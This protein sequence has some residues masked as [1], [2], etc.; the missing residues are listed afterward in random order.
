VVLVSGSGPQDRD[1][2]LFGHKPFL[3]LADHLA[4]SGIGVLRYD[5]RGVGESEGDFASATTEDFATDA[6][7]AVDYLVEHPGADPARVGIIGHSE[8][9]IVAPIAATRSRRVAFVVSLA[10]T[11]IPGR[12]LLEL[13]TR[14][15]L[16]ASGVPAPLVELNGRLQER[17]L[18]LVQEAGDAE[19]ALEVAR[20]ELEGAW[21]GLPQAAIEALGLAAQVDRALE[22]QVRRIASPW[23]FFFLSFDPATVLEKVTVPVLAVNGSLDL[24]VPPDPNLRLIRQ[25][26]E[27]GGNQSGTVVELEGLN[28]LFQTAESGLPSEYGRI[29][30]TMA[31]Q[32][33][34]LVSDWILAGGSSARPTREEGTT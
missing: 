23:L 13:Q 32:V 5:D 11:G 14:K 4:R 12:D 10:G 27:R 15:I 29:E 26:L 31:P 30:E 17:F 22:E 9:G 19:G 18:N 25:A 34:H 16:E 7:A 2:A 1:E 21:G 8:G 24:Q 28:H 6:L 3:V 20:E 33:L